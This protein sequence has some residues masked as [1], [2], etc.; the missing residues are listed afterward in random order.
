MSRKIKKLTP[1]LLRKMVM[2]EALSGKIEPTESVKAEEV[3]A[4][5]YGTEKSLEKDIDH[6]KALKIE[7]TRL[8]RRLKKIKEARRIIG[9]RILRGL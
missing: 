6:A 1:S 9:K 7:E 4:S 8:T 5:E 3:E 2:N